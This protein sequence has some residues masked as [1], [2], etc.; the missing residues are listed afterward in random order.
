MHD[1]I[2]HR[3]SKIQDPSVPDALFVP[4]NMKRGRTLWER[5]NSIL[6][7]AEPML[8]VDRTKGDRAYIRR[9]GDGWLFITKDPEDTI[10]YP[11]RTPLQRR[12]R[13]VWIDGPD[14]IR[15]GYLQA[16]NDR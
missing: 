2:H 11:L 10:Y 4:E 6:D 15:R 7:V 3:Q 1:E 5:M 16:A 12:P 13:Y 9:Q 8:G 14:G